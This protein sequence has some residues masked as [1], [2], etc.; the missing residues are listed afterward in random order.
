MRPGLIPFRQAAGD[1]PKSPFKI[2]FA[3]LKPGS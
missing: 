1:I 2:D 3:L